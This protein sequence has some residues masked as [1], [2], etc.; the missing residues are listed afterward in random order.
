MLIVHSCSQTYLFRISNSI[1]RFPTVIWR[2]EK[3]GM[4][5]NGSRSSTKLIIRRATLFGHP[6]QHLQSVRRTYESESFLKR[7]T[8]RVQTFQCVP[9]NKPDRIVGRTERIEL[10][11]QVVNMKV[12]LVLCV[13]VSILNGTWSG[14]NMSQWRIINGY[15]ADRIVILESF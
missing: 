7:N 6:H 5:I 9:P 11:W 13:A 14:I 15:F 4:A 3:S 12:F 1:L 8:Y 10:K 2:K